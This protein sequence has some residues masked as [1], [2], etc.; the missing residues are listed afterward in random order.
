MS[1]GS[2]QAV[3]AG[4]T[5]RGP[6]CSG[7]KG[8]MPGSSR[9]RPRET[10]EA[11]VVGIEAQPDRTASGRGGGSGGRNTS[12][13]IA[14]SSGGKSSGGAGRLAP[15]ARPPRRG[16]QERQE[17]ALEPGAAVERLDRAGDRRPPAPWHRTGEQLEFRP[18]LVIA[19]RRVG[20]A[21]RR[22][23]GRFEHPAIVE[24]DAHRRDTLGRETARELPALSN[25]DP[26]EEAKDALIA[27]ALAGDVPG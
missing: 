10:S 9:S 3:T 23:R 24:S 7:R 5:R 20:I 26:P 13:G 6:P 15:L 11:I 25:R 27:Q 2:H 22:A 18:E 14:G 1:P 19:K 16:K 21:A 17:V 8:R 4:P 12:V